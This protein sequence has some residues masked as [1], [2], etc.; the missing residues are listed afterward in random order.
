VINGGL[1]VQLNNRS[2]VGVNFAKA[3][4]AKV[5]GLRLISFIEITLGSPDYKQEL[6]RGE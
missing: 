3:K 2:S 5:M 6:L 4:D 1:F